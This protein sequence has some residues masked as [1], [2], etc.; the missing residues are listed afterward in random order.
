MHE[1]IYDSNEP[2]VGRGSACHRLLPEGDG[3]QADDLRRGLL[4]GHHDARTWPPPPTRLIARLATTPDGNGVKGAIPGLAGNGAVT[5]KGPENVI[6]VVLG[7]LEA[8]NG[9]APMPAYG[10]TMSDQ[11][12]ADA[13]NY[14]RSSWGNHAPAD[15]GPGAIAAPAQGRARPC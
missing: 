13:V 4:Q 10:A 2:Y 14:V 9:L 15:V 11:E 12:I 3:R 1:V 6:R 8:T 5:A 7:G